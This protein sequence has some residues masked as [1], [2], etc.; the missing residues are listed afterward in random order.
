MTAQA[1]PRTI[2]IEA[3]RYNPETD[4]EP[5]WK[6]YDVPFRD[7]MSVLQGLQYIKDHLDGSLTFRWSCRMAICGSC[8]FMVN[9]VPQLGCHVFLRDLLPGPVRV[10]PLAN[11]PVLRDLVAAARD[12]AG[13]HGLTSHLL[14]FLPTVLDAAA[15]EVRRANVPAGWAAPAFDVLQHEGVDMY[16][17]AYEERLGL[18]RTWLEG[19]KRAAA[20]KTEVVEYQHEGTTLQGYLAY[21]DSRQGPRPSVLI[22][23]QW[24]GLTAYEKRR[25]EMLAGLG[26]VAFAVDI[27]GKGVRPETTQEAGQLA[28][29]FKGDRA[30]LRGRVNAGLGRKSVA[31]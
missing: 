22:V 23:H 3:M 14:V 19:G 27:Y 5:S 2:R 21:D 28:G 7:D 13:I 9:G 1:S 6:S 20:I 26:Y 24:K 25:A 18:L 30:M 16:G 31:S 15:P 10:E 12:E 8:G 4:K 17:V 11:F 29:K